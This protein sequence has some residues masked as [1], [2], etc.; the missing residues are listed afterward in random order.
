MLAVW[1]GSG[2][3]DGYKVDVGGRVFAGVT[4]TC[5]LPDDGINVEVKDGRMVGTSVKE[6][7]VG[8]LDGVLVS[9]ENPL[10]RAEPTIGM[11]IK[12]VRA[13][14]ETTLIGLIGMIV[15]IGW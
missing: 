4:F 8:V 7:L 15:R 10:G 12:N 5:V 13:L 6:M 11:E 9:A 14:A 2:V 3:L 1:V